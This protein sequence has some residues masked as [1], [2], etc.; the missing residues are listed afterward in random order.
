MEQEMNN[1]E[2]TINELLDIYKDRVMYETKLNIFI[3]LVEKMNMFEHLDNTDRA[4]AWSSMK[5]YMQNEL[6]KS[7]KKLEEIIGEPIPLTVET[8][9]VKVN[10]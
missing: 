1:R 3:N 7:H 5:T 9:E 8:F 2:K 10:E 4:T 6:D